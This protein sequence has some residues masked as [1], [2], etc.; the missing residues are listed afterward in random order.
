MNNNE[1]NFNVENENNFNSFGLPNEF[2]NNNFANQNTTVTPLTDPIKVPDNPND[3]QNEA[4]P[5][6]N[7][8]Y[9]SQ[10]LG[11]NST[12]MK[13]QHN[14]PVYQPIIYQPFVMPMVGNTMMMMGY[15][16]MFPY[17]M[18]PQFPIMIGYP[19]MSQYPGG[20]NLST[21]GWIRSMT[22]RN[23]TTFSW[24]RIWKTPNAR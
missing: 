17:P 10:K 13:P 9:I 20:V 8:S 12:A 18:M 22:T 23:A 7:S 5:P 14:K 19:Q 3:F 1:P 21:N 15:P 2:G 24:S 4:N 16:Q 11:I 6:F